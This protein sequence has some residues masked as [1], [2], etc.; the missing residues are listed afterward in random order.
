[1]SEIR[2]TTTIEEIEVPPRDPLIS[3]SELVV[4]AGWLG[5]HAL[6]LT[7]TTAVVGTKLAV[8]GGI[9]LS[10]AIREHRRQA[11]FSGIEEIMNRSA[12]AREAL[13][14]LVA[15][16]TLEVPRREAIALHAKLQSLVTSNDRSGIA[17]LAKGLVA[18]RQNRLQAQLVPLVAEACRSIGFAPTRIDA[19]LGII[20]ATGAGRQL[21]VIEV[22]KC[23]DGGVQLHSDTDGFEGGAC[24]EL[25]HE[26]LGHEL[27]ARGVRYELAERRRK[28][29][30]P[31]YDGK[32][33]GHRIHARCTN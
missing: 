7:G 18:A 21:A 13:N 26:P 12:S 24:V 5:F 30:R 29:C 14:S 9:A 28:Q 20:E 6:K 17:A 3:L 33:L 19:Q 31:A 11:T 32:R 15:F 27:Q 8:Q 23:K 10:N 25:F 1:M 16:P 22:A 4:G 2:R